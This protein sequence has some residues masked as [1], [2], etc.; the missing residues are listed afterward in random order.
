M[1]FLG[2]LWWESLAVGHSWRRGVA[3]KNQVVAGSARGACYF[4][5]QSWTSS[6]SISLYTLPAGRIESLSGPLAI[7]AVRPTNGSLPPI[8]GTFP[9]FRTGTFQT[10][11]GF[12][13]I[14]E[15]TL[16]W[17]VQTPIDEFWL[18][19]QSKGVVLPYWLLML[20]FA[21]LWAPLLAW[22]FRRLRRKI[23][24]A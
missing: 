17:A 22:R 13:E 14:N 23:S 19:F 18:S 8:V 2:W 3:A 5:R 10:A 7:S 16:P 11:L 9:A 4:F 12:K 20:A 24:A 15:S 6:N 1:A 21:L